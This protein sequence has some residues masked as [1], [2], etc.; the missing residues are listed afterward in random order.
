ML[1]L[2]SEGSGD[3]LR[4]MRAGDEQA[5]VQLYRAHQGPVYRFA[6]HM[7]GSPEVAEEVTQEVFMALIRDA[8]QYDPDRAPLAAY[9]IGVAR[10]MVLRALATLAGPPQ[11]DPD[12]DLLDLPD[13]RQDI[14]ADLAWNQRL[15]FLRKAILSLPPNYREVVVLCDLGEMDYAEAAGVLGCAVGTVRSRLHRARA[16]LAEKMRA[17]GGLE[18]TRCPA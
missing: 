2:P 12:S 9:L 10:N 11:A 14:A 13:D 7:S 17:T 8:R 18:S 15:E 3:L 1:E 5:F 4:R 16:L 6:L